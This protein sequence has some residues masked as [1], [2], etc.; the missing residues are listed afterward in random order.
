[1]AHLKGPHSC[2]S[3][4]ACKWPWVDLWTFQV[5]GARLGTC[6]VSGNLHHRHMVLNESTTNGS[7]S[8]GSVNFGSGQTDFFSFGIMHCGLQHNSAWHYPLSSLT[9]QILFRDLQGSGALDFVEQL[10]DKGWRCHL[11]SIGTLSLERRLT[12]KQVHTL[13]LESHTMGQHKQLVS[14]IDLP[15]SRHGFPY[16]QTD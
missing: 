8:F 9:I 6:T 12:N 16:K 4:F 15:I 5:F 3:S 1:M 14:N 13:N 10:P 2:P 11:W 7:N